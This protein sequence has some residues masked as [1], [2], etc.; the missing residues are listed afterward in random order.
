MNF[1]FLT[2]LF[3]VT[4]QQRKQSVVFSFTT[5]TTTTS[6][7]HHRQRRRRR[8]QQQNGKNT[9]VTLLWGKNSNSEDD[10]KDDNDNM[11]SIRQRLEETLLSSSSSSSYHHPTESLFSDEGG[12]FDVAHR[13]V[14]PL[15]MS[16]NDDGDDDESSSPV[17]SSIARH[18]RETEIQILTKLHEEAKMTAVVQTLV[19]Q[20][21]LATTDDDYVDDYNY[22]SRDSSRSSNNNDNPN[23]DNHLLESLQNSWNLERG[24]KAAEEL[25]T[26]DE[27][28]LRY[29]RE[30]P[31]S[32]SSLL[33]MSEDRL[34]AL[35]DNQNDP[36]WAEPFHRLSVV[37][38]CQGRM[39]EARQLEEWVLSLK[40]WHI[41]ALSNLVR[42]AEAQKN[43]PL[44]IQMASRRLPIVYRCNGNRRRIGWFQR[45]LQQAKTMLQE[46]EECTKQLRD[47]ML[48]KSSSF[49]LS[50]F[51]AF[52]NNINISNDDVTNDDSENNNSNNDDGNPQDTEDDTPWQ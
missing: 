38:Y 21:V 28:L 13:F 37:Y 14:H 10:D 26:V 41:P 40:P 27:Y 1:V 45:A 20:G 47:R 6:I 50:S 15:V 25:E 32:S 43:S 24:S 39:E 46:Q 5:T 34:H 29:H 44:A 12:Q 9:A 36:Y 33:Q 23:E 8:Q 16:N 2:L 19:S 51:T 52:K 30:D 35:I 42:I 48:Q 4:Q 22:Y 3:F 17:L 31:S 7:Q 49:S 18:R 11:N